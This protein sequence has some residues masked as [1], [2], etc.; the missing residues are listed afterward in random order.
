MQLSDIFLRLGE[1]TFSHLM[2]AISISRL[3]TFQLYERAKTRLHLQKL[4]TEA[5]RKVTPRAW[6]R[7]HDGDT[8]LAAELGQA[9][10]VSHL[11]MIKDVLD[12]LGVPHED[13]FFAK[14]LDASNILTDGWQQRV[15]DNFKDKY[16]NAVLLFYVNHLGWEVQKAEQVFLPA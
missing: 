16:S 14:D 1:D 15:L 6:Q 4:N 10:L 3:K 7:I 8:E 12:F 11:D 9:I 2:R 13:G 5:L